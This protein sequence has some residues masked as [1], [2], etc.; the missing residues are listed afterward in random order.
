VA[1]AAH[2]RGDGE[3][4]RRL[5][6]GGGDR[7]GPTLERGHALLEYRHRR[8][9]E[10]RIDVAGDLHVEKRGRRIGVGEDERGALVDRHRPRAGRRIRRLAGVDRQGVGVRRFGGAMRAGMIH[11]NQ[12][13]AL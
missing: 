9:G 5:A 13:F 6:A 12:L 2:E 10:P 4:Q 1:A 7:G 8:I 11:W 3:V